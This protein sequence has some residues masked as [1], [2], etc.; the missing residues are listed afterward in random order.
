MSDRVSLKLGT[1]AGPIR[2]AAE[3][4]GRNLSD[5][6]RH[7][8]AESL[9]VSAPTI[10]H[11]NHELGKLAQAGVQARWASTKRQQRS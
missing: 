2:A 1:L 11:G 6:I 9:G 5:E 4:S 7:R 8:L 3:E 10:E